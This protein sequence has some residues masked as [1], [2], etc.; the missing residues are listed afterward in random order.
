M[1][2]AAWAILF[3]HSIVPHNHEAQQELVVCASQHQHDTDLLD[4]LGHIF[5][6]STGEDHFED[7]SAESMNLVFLLPSSD[8]IATPF[9]ASLSAR[10]F[11]PVEN[12]Q[13]TWYRYRSLRAPPAY[14]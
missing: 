2:L 4:F 9:F 5:H 12:I 7:F 3:A 6:F 11:S 14:S 13:Q 10:Y 8:F 1:L